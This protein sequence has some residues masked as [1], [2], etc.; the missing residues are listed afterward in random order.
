MYTWVTYILVGKL[1]HV[2][3][4]KNLLVDKLRHEC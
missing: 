3:Q 2:R 4:D 1:R